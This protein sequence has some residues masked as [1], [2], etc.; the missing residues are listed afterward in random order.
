MPF[1]ELIA[2]NANLALKADGTLE[3]NT[4]LQLIMG[5]PVWVDLMWDE[6]T[7]QLGIRAVNSP[8]GIPVYKEP[9]TGEYRVDSAEILAAANITVATTTEAEPEM[10][11]QQNLHEGQ[12][13]GYNPIYYITIPE[14]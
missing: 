9:E 3:W 14:P 2:P 12:W 11:Y 8:T 5:D 10:W 6:A 13:F 1:I 7:R 4:A